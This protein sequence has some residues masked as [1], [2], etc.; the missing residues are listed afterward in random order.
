MI[1][2]IPASDCVS[3]QAFGTKLQKMR[4]ALVARFGT[5][6][7]H[8]KRLPHPVPITIRGIGFFDITHPTPQDGVAP[9]GIELHP[10]LGIS[11]PTH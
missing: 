10:V 5:P 8:T 9:N 1:A 2:E 3:D 11:L 7:D 4:D 6:G